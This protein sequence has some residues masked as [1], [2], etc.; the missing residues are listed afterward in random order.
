[1]LIV[2]GVDCSQ[3]PSMLALASLREISPQKA[4]HG[5]HGY[6]Q[7]ADVVGQLSNTVQWEPRQRCCSDGPEKRSLFRVNK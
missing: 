4:G 7:T 2:I 1:M 6:V 5:C 3:T